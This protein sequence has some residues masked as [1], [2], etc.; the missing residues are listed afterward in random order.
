M[1]DAT[2]VHIALIFVTSTTDL[3]EISKSK[4]MNPGRRLK[5]HKVDKEMILAVGNRRAINR[6]DFEIALM[7]GVKHMHVRE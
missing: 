7:L 3:V 6:S 4:P 2:P 1:I 5:G